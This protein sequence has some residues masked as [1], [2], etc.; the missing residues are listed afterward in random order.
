MLS[1]QAF[2]KFDKD[3]SGDVYIED[4]LGVYFDHKHP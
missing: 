2:R 1:L 3:G 4:L